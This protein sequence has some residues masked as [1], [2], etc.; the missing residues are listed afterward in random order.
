MSVCHF[1]GAE[2]EEWMKICQECG[3]P[4]IDSSKNNDGDNSE[5]N[6]SYSYDDGEQKK[7]N[8][9]DL[10]IIIAILSLVLVALLIYTIFVVL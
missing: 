3:N 1:C 8:N 4:V 6:N 2:N 7:S 5:D 10:K 9:M